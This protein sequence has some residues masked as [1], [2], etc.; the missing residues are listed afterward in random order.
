MSIA[1]PMVAKGF[2]REPSPLVSLPSGEVK[3]PYISLKM[4]PSPV[5]AADAGSAFE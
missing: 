5:D 1:W 2:M 4:Q 3:T